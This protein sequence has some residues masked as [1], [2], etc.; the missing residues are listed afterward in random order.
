MNKTFMPAVWLALGITILI[1]ALGTVSHSAA[2]GQTN[3]GGAS[4]REPAVLRIR[5]CLRLRPHG[6]VE[7]ARDTDA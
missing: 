4:A 1:F 3:P 5:L 2:S 6:A 7:Y